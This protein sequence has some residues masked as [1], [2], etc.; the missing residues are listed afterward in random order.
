MFWTKL[1]R[2]IKAGFVNFWRNGFVSLSAVLVM[3]VTLF[4]IGIL[5]ISGAL[6]NA[7]L[8][9]LKEKVDIN[10]YFLTNAQESDVLALRKSLEAL[11]SVSAVEY[12]SAEQALE[13]FKIRHEGDQTT[14]QALQELD[15]NPLGA[16]FNIRAIDPTQ[17]EN[18]AKFLESDQ[19][20]SSDGRRII[21]KVNYNQNKTAI[22]ALTRIIQA[23]QT[24]GFAIVIIFG[25]ISVMI[26]FNTLRLIIYTSREEIAVM[27]LVGASSRYIRGPFVVSAMMYAVFSALLTLLLLYPLVLWL[28]P[29]TSQ[30][31]GGISVSQYFLVHLSQ[32]AGIL[33]L[34][35]FFLAT[36][37]SWLAVQKYLRV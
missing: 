30:F 36:I 35:G 22:D 23:A 12:V 9:Q 1:K 34:A 20:L 17:Y 8:D 7:T 18:I 33:L 28:G 21:D 19:V 5:L 24:L 16:A 37:S 15:D 25:V 32:L 3:T 6:L 13:A 29:V 26:T 10:V 14:L 11:P 27:R 31:F 2:V 4:I